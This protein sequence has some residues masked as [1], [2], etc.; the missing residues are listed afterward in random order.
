MITANDIIKPP[1]R[2]QDRG[3]LRGGAGG[4]SQSSDEDDITC[5][6]ASAGAALQAPQGNAPPVPYIHVFAND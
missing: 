6:E 3:A 4:V 2:R 5:S 1:G